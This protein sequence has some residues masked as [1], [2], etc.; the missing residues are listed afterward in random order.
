MS[1][2]VFDLSA[3]IEALA[4]QIFEA[5]GEITPEIEAHLDALDGQWLAKVESIYLYA[6]DCELD[7]DKASGWK[8][9]YQQMEQMYTRKSKG[10]KQ[11]LLLVMERTGRDAVQTPR[12]AFRRKQSPISYRW[13]GNT[14]EEIPEPFRRVRTVVTLDQDK[15]KRAIA[16]GVAVPAE[17]VGERGWHI[18]SSARRTTNQQESDN[19]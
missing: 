19:A 3:E 17:I 18:A 13:T 14:Y 11:L 7:A 12:A 8:E 15:I 5:G 1:P 16:E 10:L 9:H 6:R 4:D 2:S